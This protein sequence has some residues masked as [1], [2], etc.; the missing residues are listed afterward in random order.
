MF[1]GTPNI[2]ICSDCS[3]LIEE[4]V[5]LSGNT[6]GAIFYTD[7]KMNAP[8][9]PVHHALF[10]CPHCYSLLWS[11]DLKIVKSDEL[12][13]IL[14]IINPYLI[15]D[16]YAYLYRANDELDEEKEMYLRVEAWHAGNEQRRKDDCKLE[17][18]TDEVNNLN[19]L[20]G[21]LGSSDDELMYKAEIK[22]E[23]SFFSE[24]IKLLEKFDDFSCNLTHT[25]RR[26]S[27]D[28]N[29]FVALL[30]EYCEEN[31]NNGNRKSEGY[32]VG[33]VKEGLWTEYYKNGNK[34][35]ENNYIE[36]EKIGT[37]TAWYENGNIKS[38]SEF[39]CDE[40][41]AP[42]CSE[43][44]KI[45]EYF[46]SGGIESITGNFVDDGNLAGL[47]TW[48]YKNGQKKEEGEYMPGDFHVD[49]LDLDD[50]SLATMNPPLRKGLWSYWFE[51][52]Q[53]KSQYFYSDGVK[54][55]LY[56][57]YYKNGQKK[58]QKTYKIIVDKSYDMFYEPSKKILV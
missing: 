4:D 16:F 3:G 31:Y 35:L 15:P 36:G 11:D 54:D 8:M 33:N 14:D 47:C 17:L 50:Y 41:E 6:F 12:N 28:N 45:T 57:G 2:K 42:W 9:L 1:P 7:G 49:G 56:I 21:I 10:K 46:E 48:F 51:T 5:L 39:I 29:P 37:Q 22:R 34:K 55:G 13:D 52:G 40:S 23:L 53:K 32:K 24:A 58:V 19:K 38:K 44:H 25:V 43:P 30:D 27:I 20:D 26:L 18:S